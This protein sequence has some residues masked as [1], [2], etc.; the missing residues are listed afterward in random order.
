MGIGDLIHVL[1]DLDLGDHLAVGILHGHQL[2]NAAKDGLAGSGDEALTHTEQVDLGL[3]VQKLTDDVLVQRVGRRDLALGPAGVVQHLAGGLGQIGD[4]AGVQTDAALG[5]AL[6]LEDLV[7]DADGVGHAGLQG[8]VSIHQEGGVIGID[9]AVGLESLILRVEHLDPGVGHGAAGGDAVELVGDGAGSAAAA[10]DVSGA[11]AGDSAVDALGAAGAE[12]QHRAALGSADDAVGLGG[13]EA[14]VVDGEEGEGL[15]E[16][17]LDSGSPDH[18]HRLAGEDGRALGDGPDIAGEL[19]VPQVIQELLVKEALAPEVLDILI[20]EMQVLDIVDQL[21]QTCA[22]GKAAAVRHIPEEDV[23]IGDAVFV[24]SL[25]IT[26]AHGQLIEVAEHGH[27]QLLFSFH[28]MAPQILF[29][30]FITG[31]ADFDYMP[32]CKKM[33]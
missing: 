19:E 25:K 21:V 20:V 31:Y 8:V 10:A 24:S 18:H 23:E 33:Q 2:V 4:I 26:V 1:A 5:D 3:L 7:E 16:L 6:G 29:V 13:N 11:G 22:D 30:H 12:L 17:G 27:I 9:L 28:C 15:D 32:V 14:L